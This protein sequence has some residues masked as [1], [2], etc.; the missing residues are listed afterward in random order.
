MA[1]KKGNV[2]TG[3]PFSRMEMKKGSEPGAAALQC[4]RRYP[5]A[6]L[7]RGF[8]YQLRT[9]IHTNIVYA[10]VHPTHM[11]NERNDLW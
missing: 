5:V 6:L 7:V 10:A 1:G 11:H 4:L 2:V 3:N 8:T 9:H